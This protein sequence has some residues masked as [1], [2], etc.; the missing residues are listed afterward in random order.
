[1]AKA[2]R[3]KQVIQIVKNESLTHQLVVVT[4][5]FGNV[6][7]M[8][9]HCG[10]LA[11]NGDQEYEKLLKEIETL[12]MDIVK[13][14]FPFQNQGVVITEVKL[15]LNGLDD[16]CHGIYLLKEVFP[17]TRDYLLGFGERL[18]ALILSSLLNINGITTT[19]LDARE[20][21]L[22]DETYGNAE[23][24]YEESYKKIRTR[25][26]QVK[27]HAFVPGFIAAS[28]SGKMTTLGRGG[29]DFT[30]ALLAAALGADA[31]EIWTDVDGVMTADPRR[32]SQAMP[33][34]KLSYEEIMELSHFGARVV[35]PPTIQPLC[36][37][38]FRCG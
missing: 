35:Y 28:T 32:V 17:R 22:T 27:A 31:L 30:A 37:K 1:M 5:A 15:L 14:L 11:G 33:L 6:T 16:I 36:K 9:E 24:N 34:Q 21:I 19:L 18:S 23:V 4:S 29:S 38:E 26:N 12:H 2:G 7:N 10:Q 3:I 8:L 25:F 20:L 13:E